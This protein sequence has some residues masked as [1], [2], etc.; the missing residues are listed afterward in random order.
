[1]PC[2]WRRGERARAPGLFV[3]VASVTGEIYRDEDIVGQRAIGSSVANARYGGRASTQIQS[4]KPQILTTVG[5][6][7][8]GSGFFSDGKH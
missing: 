1:M 8:S 7:A 3:F 6:M 2:E 4:A 5:K